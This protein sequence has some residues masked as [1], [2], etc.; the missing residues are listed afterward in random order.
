MSTSG[1][2]IDCGAALETG[3]DFC[4]SCGSSQLTRG[5]VSNVSASSDEQSIHIANSTGSLQARSS[6]KIATRVARAVALVLIV[7]AVGAGAYFL[8][9]DSVNKDEIRKEGYDTGYDKGTSDG[10]DSGKSAGYQ[11][12]KSEGYSEGFTAGC[13]SVFT[14]NDGTFDYLVPYDPYGYDSYP[15]RYYIPSSNC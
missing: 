8:G 6:Q 4:I 14:F 5:V 15:G 9:R 11:S 10:Y 3:A 13:K 12:G 2:C 1:Y 7:S